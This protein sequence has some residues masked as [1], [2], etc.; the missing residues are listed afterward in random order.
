MRLKAIFVVLLILPVTMLCQEV[1]VE[2]LDYQGGT[3]TQKK[4]L[5]EQ[6]DIIKNSFDKARKFLQE[7]KNCESVIK[8]ERLLF[9]AK[10]LIDFYKNKNYDGKIA[11]DKINNHIDAM[12][13]YYKNRGHGKMYFSYNES[14]EHY[15][16]YF[17]RHLDIASGGLKFAINEFKKETLKISIPNEDFWNGKNKISSNELA[18]EEISSKKPKKTSAYKVLCKVGKYKI[19]QLGATDWLSNNPRNWNAYTLIDENDNDLLGE[20]VYEI[21]LWPTEGGGGCT[22]K[23]SANTHE[24]NIIYYSHEFKQN[25][26]LEIGSFEYYRLKEIY[27]IEP[28]ITTDEFVQYE[29]KGKVESFHFDLIKNSEVSWNPRQIKDKKLIPVVF[30]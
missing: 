12:N 27:S 16:K 11:R 22:V 7:S 17:L 18:D 30:K 10:T 28:F 26:N 29:I 6:H 21:A 25:P 5:S 20:G 23:V 19:V 1:V 13:T 4:F 15:E 8:C 3:N 9:E 24:R 2:H 14:Y